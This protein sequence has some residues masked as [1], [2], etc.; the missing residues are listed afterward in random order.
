M[1]LL[2]VKTKLTAISISVIVFSIMS[3]DGTPT[4]KDLIRLMLNTLLCYLLIAG[5]N[6]AR[7]TLVV[8][9]VLG[10][11]NAVKYIAL[12]QLSLGSSVVLYTMATTYLTSAMTLGLSSEMK[13]YFRAQ[14]N[15]S[16]THQSPN[17]R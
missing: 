13:Q 9:L 8:L 10:T 16:D 4:T 17:K 5:R 14:Q 1:F 12:G 3:W 2:T 6:W 11:I 15:L 7:W